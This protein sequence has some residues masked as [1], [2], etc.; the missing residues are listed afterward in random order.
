MADPRRPSVM[1]AGFDREDLALPHFEEEAALLS[2]GHA[3]VAGLDEAGRGPLAGPVAA[4]AVILD[5]FDLPLG[6]DD[7]KA[8]TARRRAFLFELVLRKAQA[9]G[10]G[11]A[12]AG[13]IDRINIR[14]A[15]FLAMRRAVAALPLRP[16]A[17][18]VDGNDAPPLFPCRV[19][20]LVKGDS[21]SL[22]VAA[23]SILAKV[24]RDRM[25]IRLHGVHPA[26]G[27]D[28]HKGYGTLLHRAALAEHGPCPIHRTSFLK[29]I[30][31][32]S[33][34]LED[35]LASRSGA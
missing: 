33:T 12:S 13:E 35:G 23:A 24:M 27:F 1:A 8:L 7:S 14:Q 10:L 4:A 18:I 5:P 29:S 34:R 2:A 32:G 22:S 19:Q 21:V 25:M 9:V 31:D 17:A 30:Q 15:T 28:A 16:D 6:V 26:Y 20:T 3:L 11:F